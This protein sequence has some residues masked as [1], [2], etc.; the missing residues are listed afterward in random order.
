M[1]GCMDFDC[2]TLG[3]AFVCN[4][5]LDVDKGGNCFCRE[6]DVGNGVKVELK[7]E[8]SDVICRSF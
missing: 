8:T 3:V 2:V 6:T 5:R 1:D 4:A 7:E